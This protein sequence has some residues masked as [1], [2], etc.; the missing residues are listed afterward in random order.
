M[1]PSDRFASRLAAH[2]LFL[3]AFRPFFLAAAWTAAIDLALW[4]GFLAAGLPLPDVPGGPVVWHVH[5]LLWG[6]GLAAIIGF[7]LTAVPEFTG[8]ASCRPRTTMTLLGLWLFARVAFAASGIVGPMPAALAEL[9]SVALLASLAAPPLLRDP[10]RRHLGFVVALGA[11]GV[12]LAGFHVDSLR[13]VYPMRWLHAGVDMV[14]I[15][16]ILAMSRIS[17]R[18]VNDALDLLRAAGHDPGDAYRAPPPRRN[19]AIFSICAYSAMQW[20][21]PGSPNAGWLALAAAAATFN[22]LNDWHRGRVLLDRW[23]AMLYTVYLFMALGYALIGL[24]HLAGIGAPS[25]GLHLLTIGAMS[26]A[27]FASMSIAGRIHGGW[28]LDQRPWLPTAAAMLAG[29]AVLRAAAGL[30]IPG[31]AGLLHASSA[32][33]IGAFLWWAL[34]FHPVLTR[35]RP[36]GRSDCGDYEPPAPAAAAARTAAP[37]P[38]SA[39]ARN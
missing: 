39:L 13:G 30:G 21:S 12:T 18:I 5:E 35:P 20:S 29:S 38:A 3:C 25:A 9:A 28:P 7:L 14:M 27:V 2:P 23:V 26:L 34:K 4:L 32:L 6:F 16:V 24:S 15:L 36:D 10:A 31:E 11:L 17:T 22:L 1:Q 19:L 37:A 8:A 33:W